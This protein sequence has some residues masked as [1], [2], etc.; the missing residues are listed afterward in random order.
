[1]QNIWFLLQL[2]IKSKS[3]PCRECLVFRGVSKNL[4]QVWI[5]KKSH[6]LHKWF[7]S[8]MVLGL[9]KLVKNLHT[10]CWEQ[11][12]TSTTYSAFKVLSTSNTVPK[13]KVFLTLEI[14]VFKIA[15]STLCMDTNSKKMLI[16]IWANFD[17]KRLYS[18]IFKH[19]QNAAF[20]L[21]NTNKNLLHQSMFI[22]F[23]AKKYIF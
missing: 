6:I 20:S 22:I 1:M 2:K 7:Q 5:C 3:F 4:L 17:W 10:A 8:K 18:N 13:T 11:F 9:H 14:F 15:S 16:K 21:Q 23:S 19:L 12:W